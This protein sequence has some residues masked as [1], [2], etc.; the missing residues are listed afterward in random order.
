MPWYEILILVWCFTHI[1]WIVLC[2]VLNVENF[3]KVEA[4][5]FF[6]LEC[7][8]APVCVICVLI[9][10]LLEALKHGN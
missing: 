4:V 2:A 8:M 5:I 9:S 10:M 1:V 3:N 7:I 6:I